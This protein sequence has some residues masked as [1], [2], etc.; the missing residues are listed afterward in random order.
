MIL[1]KVSCPTVQGTSSSKSVA[2]VKF[3]MEK[4]DYS[5]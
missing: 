3:I 2:Y 4:S 1:F 5:Y